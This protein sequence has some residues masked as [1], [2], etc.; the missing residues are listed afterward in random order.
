MRVEPQ[1]LQDVLSTMFHASIKCKEL[2]NLW[3]HPA[4]P[5]RCDRIYFDYGIKFIRDPHHLHIETC[6]CSGLYRGFA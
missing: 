1:Y 4:H 5:F 2:C 3:K 6:H